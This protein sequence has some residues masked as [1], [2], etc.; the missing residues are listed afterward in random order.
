MDKP[1]SILP[2]SSVVL[3]EI[4]KPFNQGAD[5]GFSERVSEN[6]RSSRDG[7]TGGWGEGP[8]W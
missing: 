8:S 5:P 7:F 1:K 6:T 3:R 4:Q 2:T